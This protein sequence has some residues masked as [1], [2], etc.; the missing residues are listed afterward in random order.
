MTMTVEQQKAAAL[1]EAEE[2]ERAMSWLDE[3][4]DNPDAAV[5]VDNTEDLAELANAADQVQRVV[6]KLRRREARV[7]LLVTMARAHGRS[8]TEIG[9]SL[10]VSRQAAQQRYGD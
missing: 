10:G 1:T 5:R 2:Y 8:W 7:R 6:A 3:L 4:E 9:R